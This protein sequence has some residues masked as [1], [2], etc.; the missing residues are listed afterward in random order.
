MIADTRCISVDNKPSTRYI[1]TMDLD[2]F[3]SLVRKEFGPGLKHATPANVREFLD[4]LQQEEFRAAKNGGRIE[5][6]ETATT[7][8]EILKDYFSRIL[9]APCDSAIIS[10]WTLAIELSFAMIESHYEEELSGLFKDLDV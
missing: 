8:E 3:K 4:R 6:N 10:L 2:T 9:D 1:E 5:I 7:Y